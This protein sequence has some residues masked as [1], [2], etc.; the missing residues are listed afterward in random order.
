MSIF[1]G[2][3]D[4]PA[5]I[6]SMLFVCAVAVILNVLVIIIIA[7]VGKFRTSVEVFLTNLAAS[8]IWHAGIVLPIHFKNLSVREQD[9]YGGKYSAPGRQEQT[10]NYLRLQNSKDVWEVTWQGKI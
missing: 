6:A 7:K 10:T 5:Y 9:F 2:A 1:D 3:V 8:D 4:H